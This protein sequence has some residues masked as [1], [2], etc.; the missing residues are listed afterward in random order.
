MSRVSVFIAASLDGFIAGPDNDLSWLPEPD[1]ESED[2]WG[3]G[4]FMAGIGALLMGRNTW[5]VVAGFGVDLPYGQRPLLV[6]TTRPLETDQ[7]TVRAVTGGIEACVA[8]A[9]EAAGDA[10]VYIDG[11]ALVRSALD[12]GLV[13]DVIVT[14]VPCILG[15]GIPLFVGTERRHP[16]ELVS[17]VAMAQGL[18]QLTYTIRQPA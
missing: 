5:D 8:A 12:A 6:A 11:G 15:A 9:R 3:F 14:I 7:P 2:D 17:S 4:A 10:N 13:D 18:V 1:P 16:L